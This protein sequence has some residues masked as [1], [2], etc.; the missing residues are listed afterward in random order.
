MIAE[1]SI[2]CPI[3]Q[4]KVPFD[5]HAL[6]S[7]MKFT[8]PSCQAVI[9]LAQESIPTASYAIEKYEDLKNNVQRTERTKNTAISLPNRDVQP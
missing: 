1:Q 6:I 7:G 9:G 5:A 2:P 3:C 8:C 4:T